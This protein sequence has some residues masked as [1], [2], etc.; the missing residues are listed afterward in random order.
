[1]AIFTTKLALLVSLLLEGIFQS[2]A[3]RTQ[4]I[5]VA[6]LLLLSNLFRYDSLFSRYNYLYVDRDVAADDR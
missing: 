1:M 6:G 4:I 5:K 3:R 2:H